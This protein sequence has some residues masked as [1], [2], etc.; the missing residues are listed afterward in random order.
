MNDILLKTIDLKKYFPI[1][2]GV[3]FQKTVANLKAV[4]GISIEVKKGETLALVGESGCGKS[5]FGRTIMRLYEPT[6][7]E[8]FF[9]D[10][11]MLHFPP[12]EL[13]SF[14]KNIC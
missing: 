9:E 10:K 8:I 1:K 6:A 7:G 14:R 13:R 4:D 2:K 12:R 3:L 11:N 5:T